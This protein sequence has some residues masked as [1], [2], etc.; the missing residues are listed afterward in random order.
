MAMSTVPI[1]LEDIEEAKSVVDYSDFVSDAPE[2]DCEATMHSARSN[3]REK[4][5]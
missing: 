1:K 5:Q 2:V 3:A 4:L